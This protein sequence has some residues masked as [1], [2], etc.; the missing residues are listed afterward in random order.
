MRGD[1]RKH[2]PEPERVAQLRD[3]IDRGEHGDKVAGSDPAIV[4]L[5]TDDEAAGR[6]RQPEQKTRRQLRDSRVGERPFSTPAL[7]AGYAG[8]AVALILAA[9]VLWAIL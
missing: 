9:V 5:G 3:S 7:V 1:V 8:S 2:P 4:P 6:P